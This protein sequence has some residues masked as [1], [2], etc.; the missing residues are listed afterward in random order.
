ME[1]IKKEKVDIRKYSIIYDVI[2]D[3]R[4]AMEGLLAPELQEEIIGSAEVRKVIRV[5]KIG[6][7]AGSYVSSG[8]IQRTSKVRIIRDGIELYAGKLDSLRRF[9]DD[10]REV[11]AGFEC[12]IKIE[13]FDDIKEGDVIEAYIVHEIAQKLDTKV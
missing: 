12:G 8:K 9:K 5:P 4:S 10:E 7:I 11:A 6:N 2:E 1:L 3:V 13:N